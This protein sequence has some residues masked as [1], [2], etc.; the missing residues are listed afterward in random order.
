MHHATLHYCIA[1]YVT[2]FAQPYAHTH[3]HLG[4]CFHSRAHARV[5]ASDVPRGWVSFLRVLRTGHGAAP[6]SSKKTGVSP[7]PPPHLAPVGAPAKLPC[8]PGHEGQAHPGGR[9]V[10]LSQQHPHACARALVRKHPQ[11]QE[12]SQPPKSD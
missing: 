2:L 6:E 1:R 7:P 11:K 3:K 5:R 4:T 9:G 12:H 8:T 10:L